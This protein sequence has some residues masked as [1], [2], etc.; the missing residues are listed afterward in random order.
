VGAVAKGTVPAVLAAAEIDRSVLLGRVRCGAETAPFVGA[1]A[2]G[3]GRAFAAGAPVGGLA[4]LD[5]DGDG[6]FLGDDGFG[7][8]MEELVVM[9]A[10][11][12]GG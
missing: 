1:V 8:G 3:L 4:G 5:F 6:G 10:A 2:E 12:R 11:H 9:V 7:H